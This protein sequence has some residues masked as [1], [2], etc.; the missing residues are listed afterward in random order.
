MLFPFPKEDLPSFKSIQPDQIY[1]K[2]NQ[3]IS[4]NKTCIE[5][6]LKQPEPYTWENLV[7]PIEELNEELSKQWSPISHLH[8][9]MQSKDLREAY[10]QTLPLLS[11]YHTELSQNEKLYR[12]L[13]SI[14]NRDDFAVLSPAQQKII[15]NELR[16][17]KL[18][19]IHLSAEKKDQMQALQ[20]ELSQLMTEFSE[21]VLDATDSFILHIKDEAQLEGLPHQ[22]KQL[23]LSEAK[24]RNLDGY[25][26]TLSA[27]SYIAAIKYLKDRH[28]RKI[29]YE[30]YVTRAS[31][32]GPHHDKW[33][34]TKVINS[35]LT[36]RHT[37][38]QMIG[39]N[40]FAELSLV[41]KMAKKPYEVLNFLNELLKKSQPFAQD[42]INELKTFAASLDGID[43]LY[44][45]DASYYSE[46]LLQ[47]KF[48]FSQEDL[49]PYFPIQQVL[50][51]LFDLIHRLYGMTIIHQKDVEVWHKDA[52][53]YAIYDQNKQLRGG[54]YIDLYARQNK[55][56]GAWMHECT[57]RSDFDSKKFQY[58]S[59]YVTCNFMPPIDHRPA[60]LTHDDVLT[61]F[62]EFG[63]ALQ[64][65]LTKVNYPAVAGI[66]GV[67]WDAVEFPSQLMENF[68]WEKPVLD[69]IS[70]H[71]E[72]DVTLPDDLFQKMLN[73][74]HFQSGLHMIR[75]IEFS[76]FDFLLHLHFDPRKNNQ[77][78]TILNQVRKETAFIPV[79]HF[80]RFQ[81][82]FGHIFAGEYAAGYYSYKWAEVLSADAFSLFKE[83]GLFDHQ[84]GMSFLTNI[85]E[86]GGVY[87]PLDC[88]KAFRGREPRIESLLKENGLMP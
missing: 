26:L 74:K 11:E 51:G 38:A 30:A 29:M 86:T 1:T 45:W 12:A 72:T 13:L 23:A 80:N 2:I 42:E 20:K 21:N 84:T 49:R 37:I 64:H 33:D 57:Q 15:E 40:N 44:A 41:S 63:H 7:Q 76:L 79:P 71:Y 17:F 54:I 27:P 78:Q 56:D 3:L 46:K 4:H 85:L 34:N 62:H 36:I 59:A 58:P 65:T 48:Q 67:A 14:R 24:K 39:L 87:D 69:M 70:A 47:S 77:A 53:F 50:Q 10:N 82:S 32:Q 35:I 9:V 88:F 83:K 43:P 16:D 28:L 8:A 6:I 55:R 22:A 19:G 60:L 66:N 18:A 5:T 81:D 25:V 73:A 52:A 68:C 75:Q 31:D 61:L